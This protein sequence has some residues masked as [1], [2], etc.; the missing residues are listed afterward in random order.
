[1]NFRKEIKKL[2]EKYQEKVHINNL[3]LN[4][5]NIQILK[6]TICLKMEW[7]QFNI[8][9]NTKYSSFKLYQDLLFKNKFYWE[10]YS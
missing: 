5:N 4:K 2:I 9:E 10:G 8:H 1:M 6:N 3:V 7:S